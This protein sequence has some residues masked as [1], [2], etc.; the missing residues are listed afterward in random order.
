MTRSRRLLR[1]A[2]L[3]ALVPACSDD[4]V[5]TSEE[6]S[7]T[8]Q[9]TSDT[10]ELPPEL[11]GP[12]MGVTIVS[13]EVNQG[14]GVDILRDGVAVP[15]DE[16]NA[17]LIRNR[18][19]LIRVQ[20][21]ID[22]PAGWIPRELTGILHI[23]TPAGAELIRERTF[24]VEENSDP[25][26]L[27][28]GFYFSLLAD[29]ALPGTSMWLELRETD[30]NLDVASLS[31]GVS[32]TPVTSF[33]FDDTPLAIR[34]VLV[35]VL[36]E[37][38]DPPR[39]P[40]ITAEDLALFH[41]Y[42]LQQNPVQTVDLQ[43]REEPIV[44]VEQ[45]TNLG[46][47]L[48][49]TRE[50]KLQDGAAANVYYHAL[51][52]V[53]GPSVSMVAGIASLT[54]PTEEESAD[55]VAATVFHKHVSVPDEDEEDQTPTIYPPANSARTFVHELG[56]NQGFS[57]VECPNA[58][59]AGPDPTYPYADGKIGVYGFGIRDFHVYTPGA[60]HDYMTYCGNSWVSDWTWNKAFTRIQILTS[61]EGEDAGSPPAITPVLVGLR[62]ADGSEEWSISTDVARV[63]QGPGDTRIEYSSGGAIATSVPARVELLSDDTTVMIT[64]P[65]PIPLA[66]LDGIAWLHAGQRRVIDRG[67]IL[68]R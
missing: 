39:Q 65:L 64:A 8:E 54:G 49:P 45:L 68:G 50:V 63:N 22:D 34:V 14:T 24:F 2:L 17:K 36:Y 43:I 61:W 20:H 16:R 52:D 40:D 33:E 32:T 12:A 47:L 9:G 19:T 4:A 42:L 21:V 67:R 46:S 6:Q 35:P 56:H 30:K 29:E 5:G 11:G 3:L 48:A 38:L 27:G 51:V 13:V 25:R 66:E 57:H 31:E 62:S 28:S 18:D 23:A 55:R 60:S 58:S 37:Y 1:T 7:D 41:D 26:Q 44:R 59:A 53:G 15:L 10:D